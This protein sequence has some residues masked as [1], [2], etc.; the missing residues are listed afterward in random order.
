VGSNESG[1]WQLYA[2]DRAAGTRRQVTD[3]PLGVVSG[4]CTPDGEGVVWFHDTTGDEVGHWLV[5][6]FA[7]GRRR[8]LLP[9][10]DAAWTT[11]LAMGPGLVAAGTAGDDGFT[12]YVSEGG[13]PVRPLLRHAE[14]IEVMDLSQDSTLVALHH[15]EHGDNL[16]LAL[17]VVDSR[18]GEVRGEQWDGPGLG[19]V[20]EAWA[21]AAGDQRLAI[22]HERDGWQRPA[23]WDVATGERRELPLGLPGDVLVADWW[24]DGSALL[25]IHD[26]EGRRQLMRFDLATEALSPL[27]HPPGTV[28]SAAV[29]PDGEVWF[30]FNS[31]AHPASI[32][33]LAGELVLAPPGEPAPEGQPYRS[34]LFEGEGGRRLHGFVASPPSAGPHPLLALVHGGPN[35]AITDSFSPEVQAWVD[36]GFA[37]AMVNYRGSTG[38]GMEFRDALIGDPGFPEVADV[39]SGLDRLVEEGVADPDRAVV[40]GGSW[41]GYIALL[42]VGLHPDRWRAAVAAVPVGDYPAAY[43]DESPSLQAFDRSLF[44]GSP[45][46]V[47]DLYR[48]RSPLTYVDRVRAPVLILAGDN[49]SRCPIAQVLNYVEALRQ[50]GGDVELY[51]FDA[52]HGTL[53]IDERIR[54][55]RAELG[56]TLSRLE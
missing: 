47:G 32:R 8:P 55:M 12:V 13:E 49:D 16:H 19:L 15:A 45:A 5:E 34:W 18:T 22:S 54:Q 52:G 37:V 6:D 36:H 39:I 21:P 3:H 2:W 29:R 42:A 26:H 7:G 40:A 27:E 11:G 25:L 51:R 17:R 20:A 33:S 24:P 14:T 30:R 44:G 23:L 38:Y 10:L 41:G 50:K 48:E 28:W 35:M 43:E 53:V 9:G 46:E 4:D 1:T 56:F 31:G